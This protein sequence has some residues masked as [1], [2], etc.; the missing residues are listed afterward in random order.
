MKTNFTI[1]VVLLCLEVVNAYG[2]SAHSFVFETKQREY[3]LHVPNIY[4]Q[5]NEDVP[6]VVVLH[7]LGDNMNNM[8]QVG[9]HQIADT[10]NFIVA[11]PQALPDPDPLV[12]MLGAAWNSGAAMFGI[13]PNAALN[14]V[15]FLTAL[16]DTISAQYNIDPNRIYFTGFSMGGYMSNRMACERSDRVAAIASVAGTI[17]ASITC[18][19]DNP[20]ATLH[21][22]GTA[23]A[24]VNYA[25]NLSGMDAEA[26]VEFWRSHNNCEATPIHTNLPNTNTTD[27]YTVE[28]FL[29][30]NGDLGTSTEFYKVTGAD[31]TWLGPNNDIYY[32]RE[33]WRFLSSHSKASSSNIINNAPDNT[34]LWTAYPNP[35]QDVLHLDFATNNS[36]YNG[37]L[38]L[39]SDMAGHVWHLSELTTTHLDINTGSLPKGIYL[40]QWQHKNGLQTKRILIK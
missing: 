6:L 5:A 24:V 27:G 21:C 4:T 40:L 12:G 11:T 23:D 26:L 29:Y 19:P 10:A 37:G 30:P 35:T 33:I 7:G 39:L 36:P 18:S 16:V 22:H 32:T 25:N 2:Q 20:V 34:P 8:S 3:I 14:D 9:F 28:H 17:G 31:H 15:G 13:T 38:L 1:L